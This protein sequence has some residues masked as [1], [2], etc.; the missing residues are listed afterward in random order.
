MSCFSNTNDEEALSPTF[1]CLGSSNV[2][3]NTFGLK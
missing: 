3:E 2:E 1:K